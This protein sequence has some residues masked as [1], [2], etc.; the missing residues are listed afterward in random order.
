M[1]EPVEDLVAR[2][3]FYR[4]VLTVHPDV[5]RLRREAARLAEA[6]GWPTVAI[7]PGLAEALLSTPRSQRSGAAERT[8]RALLEGRRPGPVVCT[9]IDL[10][11]S[12]SLSLDALAIFREASRVT[13]LVVAWP[14]TFSDGVLAYAVP[15]HS[16]Y[17]T[18]RNPEVYISSLA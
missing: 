9:E 6:N 14:G 10:L 18:W 13:A 12:R 4:C 15:E 11:F 1:G 5:V 8:C 17:R 3:G 2:T 7:G 16:D